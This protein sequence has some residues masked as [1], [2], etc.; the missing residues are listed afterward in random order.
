M[1]GSSTSSNNESS[2]RSTAAGNSL[3]EITTPLPYPRWMEKFHWIKTKHLNQIDIFLFVMSMVLG[4]QFD[5]SFEEGFYSSL[6]AMIFTALGYIF[7]AFC[8]AEMSSSLPFSGGIYGFVRAFT[9][10]I[11]WIFYCLV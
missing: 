8:L 7:L 6:A 11:F 4:K 3:V 1:T 2:M 5:N 10:P 9:L